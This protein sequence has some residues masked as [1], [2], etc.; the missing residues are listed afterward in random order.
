MTRLSATATIAA[1][2][3]LAIAQGFGA[4]SVTKSTAKS[5]PK[6]ATKSTAKP[7]HITARNQFHMTSPRA[8]KEQARHQKRG[9]ATKRGQFGKADALAA[10]RM[11]ARAKAQMNALATIKSAG[12]RGEIARATKPRRNAANPP[13]SGTL[14]FVSATQIP[15]QG[16]NIG[17]VQAA[18]VGG[19]DAFITIVD[20]NTATLPAVSDVCVY[21]E[22]QANGDGTFTPL[23]P[24]APAV[25]TPTASGFCQ[26]NYVVGD[27]NGD[28]NSDIVEADQVGGTVSIT[29]F[30]SNG[31]G[32]FTAT[33]GSPFVVSTTGATGGTLVTDATSGFLDI[34]LVDD[35]WDYNSLP[36]NIITVPGNGDGTFAAA[37]TPVPLVPSGTADGGGYNVLLTDFDGDG[38]IDVAENDYSNG[39]LN[40]YLSSTTYAGLPS[41]TPD[42]VSDACSATFGSLTGSSGLPAIVSVFCDYDTIAVYNNSAGAFSEAAYYPVAVTASS[43]PFT[44]PEAATIADVNGDGNGDVVVTNDDTSDITVLLGNGSGGLALTSVGYAVGGYPSGAAIVEDLNG[45]GLPDI[46]VADN[47]QSLVWMA[48][49][50]DGT[51]QAARDYY[52]PVAESAYSYGYSIASG[53]FNGDGFTDLVVSNLDDGAGLTVFLSNP[54]GSLQPGVNYGATGYFPYA[55]VADFNGDGNLDIAASSFDGFVQIFTGTGTGTFVQGPTYES[56]SEGEGVVAAAFNT[57]TGV[58][59]FNDLAVASYSSNVYVLINDGAGGFMPAVPYPLTNG[60]EQ[61]AT[62]QLTAGG[63]S[64]SGFND[65]A[66][67]EYDG[68]QVGIYLGNGDGTFTA[69]AADASMG[70]SSPLGIALADVSGDGIPDIVATDDNQNILVATGFGDGTFP[71]AL[72]PLVSST[73]VTNSIATGNPYY[74]PDPWTVQVTDVN[75][76]GFADLVY[77]N[78]NYSTVGVIFGTGAGTAIAPTFY[79]PVEFPAGQN[80]IGLTIADINGDGAP[81]AGTTGEDISLATT[82]INANGT[83]AAPNFSLSSNTSF[84]NIQDGGTNTATITL[85]P[86][87]FYSGTVTFSCT[88]LPLDV[89]CAFAP[90]TLTALGNAPQTTTV[91]VT[92]AAPHSALRMPADANPHKGRTSLLA[93]LT[94]MGLFGLLLSGDWKNKRN[95]RVGIVLGILVLGMMFT[96]VGCSSSTTPGTP[97]GAQTV[98]VTGTGSDGTTQAVNLTINVF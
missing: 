47:N 3:L 38:L 7:Y 53:D 48:G 81:D 60:G 32:T 13:P 96:L 43:T 87:N 76:D 18:T 36:S 22:V 74:N 95:R 12:H 55:A 44:F 1:L 45:D 23:V 49:F 93:C 50:G 54:D 82:L 71:N 5:S 77:T 28:G 34:V 56:G 19:L 69:A 52:T 9:Q 90:A 78:E 25:L 97:L 68:T 31:D 91:T 65:L 92:T 64:P 72:I 79:D 86:V 83:G 41:P 20:V 15:D 30:L 80:A 46:L 42:G 2:L 35:D 62:G 89:T 85:T 4:T 33:P 58:P 24:T 70:T 67:A 40:V 26:H 14:G 98:Q 8:L 63:A 29:V 57:K 21:S 75:G 88:G 27:V 51:F 6:I 37:L 10:A 84:I 59:G 17:Q 73:I 61:I 39:E 16:E 11:N 66:V 94:G